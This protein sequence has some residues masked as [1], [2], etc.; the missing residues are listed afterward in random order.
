MLHIW[1][2]RA[3]SGKSRR[4][5]EAMEKNRRLRRQVLLVPEHISHEAE[6]DLC[7]ALG[8][9][10][11]R[12]AEVLSFRSLSSRVLAETGGLAEFTL[13][14]GGKLLT[15]R[16]VLQELAPELRV[17]GRPSQRAS[18]LRQLTDL[19]EEFYAYEIGPQALYR[20]VED[21]D[22]AMGGKLRDIALIY[23]AYDARLRSGDFDAR[24]RLQKL[25]EHLEG[26]G[27]LRGCDVYLL[28][29]IHI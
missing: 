15:M 11:S 20:Q 14:N 16:R 18:F 5:L 2:G 22:G 19:T 28:S 13:D 25:R 3:G 27:Y 24:S 26:S 10:A 29:L 9:T 23:A 4:V 17:F 6:V 12:D 1:V 8:P 21:L 7:R